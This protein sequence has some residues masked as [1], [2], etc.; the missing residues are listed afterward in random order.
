CKKLYKQKKNSYG[1]F[2]HGLLDNDK[3]RYKIFNKINPN[4]KG[5][6]FKKYKKNTIKD[7]TS[8]IDK[9]VDI[10]Y[11]LERLH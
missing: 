4:Y 7:F 11:I 9:H 10:N 2:I 3:L 8:H 6:N 1:T 5:Y